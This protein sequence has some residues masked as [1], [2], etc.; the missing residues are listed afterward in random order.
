M[1]IRHNVEQRTPDWYRLRW[2]QITGSTLKN[3]FGTDAA[4]ERA[5]IKLSYER[6][7]PWH[8]GLIDHTD[9]ASMAYGRA[10]EPQ[11]VSNF[12]LDKACEVERGPVISLDGLPLIVSLDALLDT[13]EPLE[14]KCPWSMDVHKGYIANGLGDHSWQ[15]LAGMVCTG[16]D[17]GWFMSYD[18]REMMRPCYYSR[19]LRDETFVDQ[20]FDRVTRMDEMVRSGSFKPF[21]RKSLDNCDEA[22]LL[23]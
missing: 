9:S 14:I 21:S 3:L 17:S 2:G 19:I 1:L 11:A 15:V 16:A 23:F 7:T 5:Y 4:Q 22:V 13:M 10:M 6:S 18:P 20:V 8:E 12:E